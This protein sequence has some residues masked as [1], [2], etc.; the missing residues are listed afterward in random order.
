MEINAQECLNQNDN[1]ACQSNIGSTLI[2]GVRP[3]VAPKFSIVIPTWKRVETLKDT[4]ESALSQTWAGDF[5]VIVVED[6]P[7]PDSDVY[8]YLMSLTDPRI[9]YYRNDRNLGLVGNFNRAVSLADGEYAVLVHDDDY[10]FPAYL[11]EIDRI[12][13]IAQDA[14]I[15]CPEAV[16]WR[17]YQGQPKPAVPENKVNAKLWCPEADGEPFCRLFAPTGVTFRKSAFMKSGGFDHL[18]G[19]STDLYFIV[20]AA[21][22]MKYYR[23]EKPLF[24]YR[25]SANESLKLNVRMDFLRAGLPLRKL[26]LKRHHAPGFLTRA[27]LKYYCWQSVEHLKRDFPEEKPDLSWLILPENRLEIRWGKFVTDALGRYL[28]LRRTFSKSV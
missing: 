26:L 4:V 17:E 13:G 10:L 21:R 25:W 9:I 14:D 28:L 11:A 19:P 16:K 2:K 20:R 5:D 18:S 1:F 23:Y 27:L 6:N 12:T 15:I 24:V 8:K 22:S 7:E 3:G